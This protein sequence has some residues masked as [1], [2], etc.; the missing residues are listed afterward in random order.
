M[1]ADASVTPLTS[2]TKSHD[3]R[4]PQVRTP[5]SS[6]RHSSGGATRYRISLEGIVQGVG[7]RPF[8]KKLADRFQLPGIAFNT[9][10]GLVVEVETERSDDAH[11]FIAAIAAE[12]P[13]A[14]KI[15]RFAAEELI[16]PAGYDSF[17]ILSSADRDQKLYFD[18][19]GSGNLRHMPRRDP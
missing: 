3:L 10:G 12:A 7:F 9:A 16:Q 8:V 17:R 4:V 2:C 15:D 6:E 11:R 19:A 14:A 1:L 13:P 5:L 18:F